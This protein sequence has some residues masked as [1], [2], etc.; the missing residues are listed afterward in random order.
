ML[1]LAFVAVPLVELVLL[2]F[3]QD[4]IG[5]GVTIGVVLV[6]G[7][8]GAWL[9]RHQGT[10]TWQSARSQFEMGRL[11]NRELAHGA[12]ILFGGALLLTPGFLTDLVGFSLMVPPIR[13][14]VRRTVTKRM[15][16]RVVV[17]DP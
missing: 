7:V 11:P 10:R 5:L 9:V 12:M 16:N 8:I 4:R 6:T 2:V 17:I 3:L 1:V 13:E 14:I 15:E